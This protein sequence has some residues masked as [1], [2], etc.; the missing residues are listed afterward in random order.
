VIHISSS[1]QGL[2][3]GKSYGQPEGPVGVVLAGAGARGS[4]EAGYLATLLKADPIVWAHGL[5]RPTIYVGTSAGGIN[6]ALFA[7]LAHLAPA[8]MAD[9]ALRRWSLVTKSRVLAPA[10]TSFSAALARYVAGLAGIGDGPTALFDTTPLAATL[11]DPKLIDWAQLHANVRSGVV[12]VVAVVTTEFGSGRTKVFFETSGSDP[13]WH[14]MASD[15]GEAIDYVRTELGPQ[16][17]RASAAIPLAFSPVQLGPEKTATWHMDGG[18]RLNAPLK[19]ALK[20]GA[21]ALVVIATDPSRSGTPAEADRSASSPT[22]QEAALQ[23]MRGAMTDRMVQDVHELL[24]RNELIAGRGDG[25]VN[26]AGEEDRI[27]HLLFGGP[28]TAEDVGRIAAEVLPGILKGVRAFAH[29]DLAL[30]YFLL[31]IDAKSR[32]NLLSYLLFEPEF[33]ERTID[34]GVQHATNLL[35]EP[36]KDPWR[37]TL[38]HEKE[39]TL[40][41]EKNSTLAHEKDSTLAYEKG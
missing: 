15:A 8:E 28:G 4:Y 21:N 40:A 1:A 10:I 18:V 34:L 2:F 23:L 37:S 29:L 27:I 7:S 22:M 19:P 24:R 39:S 30:L 20:F 35:A 9:E 11:N 14:R 3:S 25:T 13:R 38:A 36:R 33:I 41:H 26:A 6:A 5:L 17:L 31:S 16:H 12:D 32:P